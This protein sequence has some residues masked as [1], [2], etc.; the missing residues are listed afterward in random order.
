MAY[1]SIHVLWRLSEFSLW[2]SHRAILFSFLNL[3]QYGGV[4]DLLLRGV[5]GLDFVRIVQRNS[6]SVVVR[7]RIHVI[8][9]RESM[10]RVAKVVDCLGCLTIKRWTSYHI[11]LI[12]LRD[13]REPLVSSRE[14]VYR[15]GEGTVYV[16]NVLSASR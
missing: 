10:P 13:S 12:R 14:N 15:P 11:S 1:V 9:L 16:L 6:G 7:M 4:T 3:L 8:C 2:Q 5:R